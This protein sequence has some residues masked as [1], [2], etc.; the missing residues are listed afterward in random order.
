MSKVFFSYSHKDEALRD[1]LE[2]HLA[3]LKNQGLIESWH[4]R[5]IV[6]GSE[7]GADI[8]AA[9]EDADIIL[10]LVSADFLASSYCYSIEMARAMERHEARA[11]R[12]IPVILRDCDWHSSPFGKLTAVPTDGKPVRSWPDIDQ[13]FANVAREVRKA[14]QGAAPSDMAKAT[15][16]VRP[17][18]SVDG[19]SAAKGNSALRSSNLRLKKS[20]SEHDKDE[21]L[22][23]GFEYLAR[24]FDGSLKALEERNSDI[25]TAFD[26]IDSRRFSAAIYQ[27]GKLVSECSVRLE[28][29]G[30]SNS[31]A[32]SFDASARA[33]SFNEMLNV[34]ADDQHLYF[35]AMGMQMSGQRAAGKLTDEGAAEFLWSLVLGRL[36]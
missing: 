9:L 28:G 12:V 25:K 13:A 17:P 3:Q 32:F 14:V 27:Q 16:V 2:T 4:D 19:A 8:S 22:R 7:F 6:A 23:E 26:R 5:R 18:V 30:R 33:G 1:Q 24:F 15:Q 21:Y 36:Q 10:L 31:I 11:A 29:L 34:E 35:K 20:F